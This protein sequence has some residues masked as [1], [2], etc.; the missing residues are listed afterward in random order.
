M[1]TNGAKVTAAAIQK[2][3]QSVIKEW[4]Q[5][6]LP[7]NKRRNKRNG[8]GAP[9]SAWMIGAKDGCKSKIYEVCELRVRYPYQHIGHGAKVLAKRIANKYQVSW[10]QHDLIEEYVYARYR[11]RKTEYF[12]PSQT[13]PLDNVLNPNG[14]S[15]YELVDL[16]QTACK[17]LKIH[18]RDIPLGALIDARF[19]NAL[20]MHELI[21]TTRRK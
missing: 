10:V 6:K 14:N 11:G 18:P 19:T 15:S 4:M 7:E 13:G 9:L 8:N 3:L 20:L 12:R 17:K 1:A 16:V 21:L 2:D 5:V